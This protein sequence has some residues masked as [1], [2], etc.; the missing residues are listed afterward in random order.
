MSEP[1]QANFLDAAEVGPRRGERPL[2]EGARIDRCKSCQAETV[3]IRTEDG[4]AMPLSVA[5]AQQRDGITYLL[6]HFAD[7]PEAKEWSKAK[8]RK[9]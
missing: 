5:T 9:R 1:T 2:P 4:R 3:W 6:P 7:C 8:G